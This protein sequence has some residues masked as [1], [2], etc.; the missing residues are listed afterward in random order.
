MIS[1]CGAIRKIK[2]SL[3]LAAFLSVVGIVLAGCSVVD[4]ELHKSGGVVGAASDGVFSAP[5]KE[6]QVYRAAIAMALIGGIAQVSVKEPQ[7][8]TIWVT[9]VVDAATDIRNM[10]ALATYN[11]SDPGCAQLRKECSDYP[12]RFE[13]LVPHLESRLYHLAVASLTDHDLGAVQAD[14]ASQNYVALALHFAKASGRAVAA[15]HQMAATYRSVTE[16]VALATLR[17]RGGDTAPADRTLDNVEDAYAYLLEVI[18]EVG[19]RQARKD[20]TLAPQDFD[21]LFKLAL[22]SCFDVAGRSNVGTEVKT[23]DGRAAR[24]NDAREICNKELV[25]KK[26]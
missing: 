12:A 9:R 26:T 23:A 24:T 11:N 8:A 2:K 14:I 22:R 10:Y 20:L 25:W 19:E 17:S 3:T 18:G 13:S 16:G 6:L 4:A 1:G 15:A 21:F 7:D 5:T